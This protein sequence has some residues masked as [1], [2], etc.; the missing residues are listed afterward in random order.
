MPSHPHNKVA[1]KPGDNQSQVVVEP[2]SRLDVPARP[3]KTTLSYSFRLM[4]PV[5]WFAPMWA[6]LC[7]AVAVGMDWGYWE[8]IVKLLLG[9]FLA[10]PILCGL[11]Q[12]L[13]DWFDREVDA[14]NEPQRLI[15]SGRVSKNQVMWTVLVL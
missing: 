15:P 3:L 13:N 7:G 10:G 9:I 4:K 8:N 2:R 14:I 11:S 5:T 12:V 6:F 1:L